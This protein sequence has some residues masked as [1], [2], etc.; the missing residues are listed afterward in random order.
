M[1]GSGVFVLKGV[2]LIQFPNDFF[3]QYNHWT[4]TLLVKKKTLQNDDWRRFFPFG[5]RY[6]L[7][8]GNHTEF[9]ISDMACHFYGNVGVSCV[10]YVPFFWGKTVPFLDGY[11]FTVILICCCV[12]IRIPRTKQE[13]EADYQRKL[14]AR[15]FRQRLTLIQNQDMDS[16]DLKAGKVVKSFPQSI[17]SST[18]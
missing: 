13:I 10:K 14:I 9:G 5:E 2:D 8:R 12:K 18:V 6:G 4:T 17:P 7:D 3:V 11:F 16:L 15:K 1:D